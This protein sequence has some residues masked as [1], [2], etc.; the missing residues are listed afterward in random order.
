MPTSN[1]VFPSSEGQTS[2]SPKNSDAHSATYDYVIVGGGAAGAVLA[3]RLSE[4]GDRKVLLLEAGMAYAPDEYPDAVRLQTMIGGDSEHD[5]G[6][7]SEPSYLN[8]V[9]PLPRGRVLGGSTAINGA[10][11]MR[12]PKVDHD[13]W[14]KEHGLEGWSWADMAPAFIR[15]ER[16]SGGADDVHGRSGPFP[17]HQLGFEE[18]SDMQRAFVEAAVNVGYPRVSDFNGTEPFG[19]SPYPMNTRM[20]NRMNTGMTYLDSATRARP[21]LTIR[22]NA[23]VD[24]VLFEGRRAVGVNLIDGESIFAHEVILSAGTY[25]SPGILMR[26]GV[27]PAQDLEALGIDVIA[28][29]PVGK[30]LQDHP[31]YFTVWAANPQKVG[32]GTPPV[33]AILWARSK[34]AAANDLDLHVTAVHYGDP[35][36]SPSGAIFMLAIANTRPVSVGSFKLRSKD[37]R[38]NPIIDLAFL[39]DKR[40]RDGLIDGVEI[41]RALAAT[42]PLSEFIQSEMAPGTEAVTRAEIEASLAGSLDTYHHPTSTVPMG[43]PNDPDAVLDNFG[44]VRGVQGLRVVDA[45]IFPDIPSVAT[46]VITLMAAEHIAFKMTDNRSAEREL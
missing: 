17:I 1:T 46:N 33:G 34:Q 18:T 27:G 5:W 44:L 26:S 8:R 31:F 30:K 45:S 4:A 22:G 14:Q 6:Y 20:G 23:E 9:L 12:T 15:M 36:Q 25:G 35:S 3:N 16:T 28:D 10:V 43:G 2:A 13:R 19:A 32:L 37:P 29:L 7:Q 11:A 40:D 24:R 21:N 38:D 41:V 42:A 39:K